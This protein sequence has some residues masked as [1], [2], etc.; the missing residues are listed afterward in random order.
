MKTEYFECNCS[1]AEHTLRFVLDEEDGELYTENHLTV[2]P[3]FKRIWKAVK[4]IFGHTSRYGNYD[5]T[6]I[7][8][9]DIDRLI[10]LLSKAKRIAKEEE[11]RDNTIG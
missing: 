3:F 8:T 2:A 6:L 1:S 5:C 10:D 9:E 7:K 11:R 4:Y